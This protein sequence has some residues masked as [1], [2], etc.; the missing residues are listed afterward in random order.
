MNSDK[1]FRGILKFLTVILVFLKGKKLVNINFCGYRFNK[2][3]NFP[4]HVIG[5]FC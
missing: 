4:R 5:K 1:N 2:R 3:W